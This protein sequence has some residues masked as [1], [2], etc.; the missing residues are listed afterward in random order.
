M[1][2]DLREVNLFPAGLLGRRFSGFGNG[3][4]V[5]PLSVRVIDV[6]GSSTLILSDS[7]E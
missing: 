3:H 7:T 5:S 4:I 1:M 6:K 2:F